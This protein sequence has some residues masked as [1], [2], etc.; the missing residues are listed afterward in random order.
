[1]DSDHILAYADAIIVL[2]KGRVVD[3]G[4]YEELKVRMPEIIANIHMSE[5]DKMVS[6][7]EDTLVNPNSAGV[8]AETA[9]SEVVDL[10]RQQGSWSV[11][12]YYFRSA[13]Y[14][15]LIFSISCVVIECF[16][17]NFSSTLSSFHKMMTALKL[18]LTFSLAISI[19][20]WVE[21][22]EREPNQHLAF[23]LGI[24]GLMFSMSF[25]GLLAGCW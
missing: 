19:Q 17:A 4:S 5:D 25:L 7:E 15:P 18:S 6:T 11:Y 13:G 24:Y 10:F 8:A 16:G 2:D 12:D 3:Q 14:I 1:M 22:N 23:Y 21:S 9:N 20:W